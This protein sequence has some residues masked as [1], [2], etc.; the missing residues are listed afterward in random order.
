MTSICTSV[1]T[2]GS[3]NSASTSSQR[4]TAPVTSRAIQYA[5]TTSAASAPVSAIICQP[6][7]MPSE[8]TMSLVTDVATI[9]RRRRC[10]R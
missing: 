9:S 5:R 10:A 1:S 2:A 8:L 7:A 3:A 4:A 6:Q